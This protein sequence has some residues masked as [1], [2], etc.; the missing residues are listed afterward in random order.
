[1]IRDL[2]FRDLLRG[3]TVLSLIFP[4]VL[5]A[6]NASTKAVPIPKISGPVPVA[7][8]SYPFNAA[9]RLQTPIDLAAHG[10]VEQEFFVSGAGNVYDWAPDGTI[11]VNSPCPNPPVCDRLQNQIVV[12]GRAKNQAV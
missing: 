5:L 12:F 6:Q 9:S 10:Y 3:G 7:A 4:L 11:S 8:E 1:M 2:M